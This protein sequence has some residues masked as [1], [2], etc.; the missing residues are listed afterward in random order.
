MIIKKTF[1]VS[2][3]MKAPT[4]QRNEWEV[5]EGDNGN[6]I[7]ITLTDDGESV[8][9]T[10]CKVLAVFGLPTGQTVEQDTDEGSVT[11]GGTD[12]NVI[13]IALKTGSFSPGKSSSGLMKCE[14]QVYS[15]NDLDTLVTSAQFTFRCR[16]AIINDDTI[17]ATDDYPILVKLIEEVQRIITGVQSDW[18][19]AD[20]S[21]PSYINNKPT[22]MDPTAH[23]STHEIGGTDALPIA[24]TSGAGLTQLYDGVDSSSTVLAATAAAAKKAYEHNGINRNLLDNWYFK[25]PVNQREQNSY[26][27]ANAYTIDRWKLTSGSLTVGTGG[28]TLNGTIVQIL[29]HSIGLTVTA[30]ALLSDG[31]MISPTYDDAAQTFTL[32][33]TGQT[34]V[35][36]KLEIGARQTLA[37]NGV[38]TEIPNISEELERCQRFYYRMHLASW[39]LMAMGVC[40]AV[41][42]IA[43]MIPFPRMHRAPTMSSPSSIGLWSSGGAWATVESFTVKYTPN[44]PNLSFDVYPASNCTVGV[45]Y[46]PVIE[47]G[48]YI[49]FNADL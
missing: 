47:A 18:D 29:E 13:T 8:D 1:K 48:G 37:E 49:E 17:A 19:E 2:L 24:T 3:D 4:A 12:N 6:I 26:S 42:N 43:Y 33:A 39:Q 7:E 9:L 23:A 40:S 22:E 20:P 11:I 25:R 21:E 5:V 35:A 10:G 31:T 32:T 41:R 15:G 45:V 30:S 38:L 14:I 34:I 36:A 27:T 46:A 28:I 16:R 44:S